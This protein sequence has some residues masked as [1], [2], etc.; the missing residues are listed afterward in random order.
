MAIFLSGI[1]VTTL[2]IVVGFFFAKKVCK[3]NILLALGSLSGAHNVTAALNGLT[4]EA[5][6]SIP[7]IAYAVPYAVANVVLTVM[8]S[9]IVN[10]M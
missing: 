3:L 6:S 2:P 1:V 9:F 8:G 10:I 5:E 7:A 4:E